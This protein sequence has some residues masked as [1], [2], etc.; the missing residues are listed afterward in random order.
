MKK[1][2]LWCGVGLLLSACG[3]AGPSSDDSASAASS[4]AAAIPEPPP[5]DLDGDGTPDATDDD[6]DGDGVS[7]ADELARG[8]NSK[9]ADT[10]NDGANDGADNCFVVANAGQLDSDNN[11]VG[12]ACSPDDD[13]DG[14]PDDLEIVQYH[15]NPK[16]AD[17][18]GDGLSD[19]AEIVVTKTDPLRADTDGDG[20]NDAKDIFPLDAKEVADHD[21]DGVGDHADNCLSVANPDQ[22]NTDATYAA[23]GIRAPSGASVVADGLGDACDDDVDG[24]G[25]HAVYVDGSRG[26]DAT[27][28]TFVAPLRTLAIAITRVAGT[29]LEI[30][31]A[32]GVYDVTTVV[33]RDGIIVRGGFDT[34]FATRQT[35]NVDPKFATILTSA[36]PATITIAARS[37]VVLDGLIVQ[38]HGAQ[39]DTTTVLVQ[40]GGISLVDC[41]V[42]GN[43]QAQFL[44][45]VQADDASTLAIERSEILAQGDGK[46]TMATAL[47]VDASQLH[48]LNSV[49]QSLDA[50]HVVAL[51][52][53]GVQA[54]VLNNT[55]L[56]G[57][58]EH[59]V[60]TATALTLANGAVI[61]ANNIFVTDTA[62]DQSPLA[63][64]G[65]D[66]SGAVLQNNLLVPI[67]GEGPQP[68]AIDC[69]GS[70]LM[71]DVIGAKP[72][73][74]SGTTF[75]HLFTVQVAAAAAVVALDEF[76]PSEEIRA[77]AGDAVLG[78]QYHVHDDYYGKER[79]AALGIGA[80][81]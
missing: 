79:G 8:T 66:L 75:D 57:S 54:E 9:L 48:L 14:L 56:A 49:V 29:N 68:L 52:Y 46:S 70:Y 13:G 6:I 50:T 3:S 15:T 51:D 1:I 28:G 19:P 81:Q 58:R 39:S 36:Q 47:A 74:F 71:S 16:L 24:D 31:V 33:W 59:A 10:D 30:R 35:K 60:S 26:D 21:G 40:H 43:S 44:T 64:V 42:Q 12:D 20:V 11:G 62:T 69:A 38:N 76:S 55:V 65:T 73:P 77:L 37:G 22:H 72:I 25:L 63:C 45:A 27:M 34:T 67:G 53:H 18:D 5:P 80:V 78:E 61:V 41:V 32:A 17:T 2:L 4:V 7:N 23:T